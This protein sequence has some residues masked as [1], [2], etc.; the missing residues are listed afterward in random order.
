V[1]F[2]A[3]ARLYERI[4]GSGENWD[5]DFQPP[6]T[7]NTRKKQERKNLSADYTARPGPQPKLTMQGVLPGR[8]NIKHSTLNA[9]LPTIK[10][11][12]ENKNFFAK[13]QEVDGQ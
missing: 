7:R 10:I 12:L 3:K 8:S 6:N 13:K 11:E 9:K 5:K 1:E 2:R 4:R